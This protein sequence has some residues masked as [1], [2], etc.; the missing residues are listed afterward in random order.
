MASSFPNHFLLPLNCTEILGS[1]ML[2]R[3]VYMRVCKWA[4]EW[5]AN[6]LEQSQF[7]VFDLD[8]Q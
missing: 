6:S 5:V 2:S 1:G 4:S 3:H 8:G 7:N